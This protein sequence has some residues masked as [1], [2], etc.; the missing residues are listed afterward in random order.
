[1]GVSAVTMR[2]QNLLVLF[3][4]YT[5]TLLVAYGLFKTTLLGRYG[6]AVI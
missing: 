6:Y 3:A 4:T 1:M 2:R 5:I